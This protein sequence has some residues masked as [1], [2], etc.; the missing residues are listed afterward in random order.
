[1]KILRGGLL[2]ICVPVLFL[3]LLLGNLFFTLSSS[4]EYENIYPELASTIKEASPEFNSTSYYL[5]QNYFSIQDYC[6]LKNSFN[7]QYNDIHLNISCSS[8]NTSLNSVFS[9]INSSVNLE[10]NLNLS[11]GIRLNYPKMID[12]CSPKENYYFS[13]LKK[14]ISCEEF[15][16]S[17]EEFELNLLNSSV[18]QV[19]YKNYSCSFWDCLSKTGSPMFLV[20]EKASNYWKSNF[21]FFLFV[22]LVLLIVIFLLLEEKINL[23]F[24]FGITLILSSLPLLKIESF[25]LFLLKPIA[26]FVNFINYLDSSS[27]ISIFSIF[28][29]RANFIFYF[30]VVIGVTFIILGIVLKFWKLITG[31]TKRMFSSRDIKQ[32]VT[33]EVK[34]EVEKSKEKNPQKKK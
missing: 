24:V 34:K 23:L 17:K 6:S 28:F 10:E 29:S 13:T 33:N 26:Y 12:A 16:I 25:L 18:S 19:Y 30:L 31:R 15:S 21:Y 5:Q 22:S 14:N 8:I 27:L 1:M 7:Y 32:L 9:E 3:S 20:S 4:L 2:L 11:S